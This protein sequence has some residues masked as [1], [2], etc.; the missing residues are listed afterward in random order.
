MWW[1]SSFSFAVGFAAVVATSNWS[2]AAN[3]AKLTLAPGFRQPAGIARGYVSGSYSLAA[4]A[5]RDRRNQPCIGF[6]SPTPD[7]IMILQKD[8]AK[9]TIKVNSGGKDTTLTIEGPNNTIRCGDDTGNSKDAS[10]QDTNWQAGEYSIWVGAIEPA[11]KW[12][13]TLSVQE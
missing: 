4:I 7:H 11:K 9:L 10:V 1:R 2:E 13:Y 5:N 3:F 8:F 12:T 6:A